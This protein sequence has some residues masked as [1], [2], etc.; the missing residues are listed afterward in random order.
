VLNGISGVNG[1]DGYTPIKGVDY[2]DG[3]DG[4]NGVDGYTPIKGVD[5]FDG[6][7]GKNYVLTSADKAEIA[8]AVLDALESAEGGLY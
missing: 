7:D 3:K 2:F 4:T 8:N 6:E 5:Y 1:K